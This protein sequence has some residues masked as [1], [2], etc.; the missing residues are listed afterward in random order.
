MLLEPPPGPQLEPQELLQEQ[1]VPPLELQGLVQWAGMEGK[2]MIVQK[3]Y[4]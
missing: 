1:Q 4:C 2:H 3:S